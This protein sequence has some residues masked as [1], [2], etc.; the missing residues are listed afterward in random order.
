MPA[1]VSVLI[2]GAGPSGLTMAIVL[3]RY[4]I[5]F[6]IIDKAIKPVQTSNALAIHART[7]Q[8]WND[9]GLLDKALEYG[10]EIRQLAIHG[11]NKKIIAH[12]D[13]NLL[14][15]SEKIVLALAQ[16]DSEKMLLE[17]LQAQNINVEMETELLDFKQSENGIEATIRHN[18]NTETVQSDWL[19]AC[20]G[21]RSIVREKLSLPFNGR[22]LP[23][24]FLLADSEIKTDLPR[25][26]L[27]AFLSSS[28]VCLLAPYKTEN[29]Q[30]W[31]FIF[32]VTHDEKLNEQRKLEFSQLKSLIAERCP[33]DA[34][35]SE[36][37]WTSGF[38]IHERMIANFRHERIFFAGDAAHV[39]SPAGGQGM[40]IGLQDAYNLGWKLALVINNKAKPAILDTYS[41]ERAPV[42]KNILAGTSLLTRLVD[43]RNPLLVRLRNLFLHTLM[44]LTSLRAKII[45]TIG[46]L[47]TNYKRSALTKECLPFRKSPK[48]GELMPDISVNNTTLHK[49]LRGEKF[50]LLVLKG[51]KENNSLKE[52]TELQDYLQKTYPDVV[53]YMLVSTKDTTETR[54][55][56]VRPDK[57]IGFRG[58]I[59]HMPEL[60]AYLNQWLQT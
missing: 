52:L 11:S 60:K 8:V 42:A 25:D 6:R 39:H 55:L 59:N 3:L 19:I 24:H 15:S 12:L 36:P 45:N 17:Y 26:R 56:L 31:R 9:L 7:L 35:V 41:N 1:K 14:K 5:S 28:G 43:L 46:E 50:I 51:L 57:Y 48:A 4:G 2:V 10:E 18:N 23:Q 32:D 47:N 58:G 38:T 30:Y 54:L 44:I 53:K 22:E 34:E 49:Q 33:I 40:N 13:M 27:S 29:K 20:D 16:H 21:I 37:I